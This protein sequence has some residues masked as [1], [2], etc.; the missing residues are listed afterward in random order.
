MLIMLLLNKIINMN[1]WKKE[2]GFVGM[3]REPAT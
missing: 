2:K 1:E 3:I